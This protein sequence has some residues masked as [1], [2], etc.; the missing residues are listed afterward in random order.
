MRNRILAG[1]VVLCVTVFGLLA[2]IS[3]AAVIKLKNGNTIE[4]EIGVITDSEVTVEIP[5]LGLMTFTISEVALIN[6]EPVQIQ[7][8]AGEKKGGNAAIHYSKASDLLLYPTFKEQK[9]AIDSVIEGSWGQDSQGLETLL[10]QNEAFFETFQNGLGVERCDFSFGSDPSLKTLPHML[11]TRDLTNLVLLKIRYD[12]HLGDMDS[13]IGGYLSLL[14]FA[15]HF[16]Q[17]R[18]FV[19]VMLVEALEQQTVRRLKEYVSSP[20]ATGEQNQRIAK[21]LSWYEDARPTVNQLQEIERAAE[22][23]Q[24]ALTPGGFFDNIPYKRVELNYKAS[25]R[26][27]KELRL[28]AVEKSG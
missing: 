15:Q 17:T 27:L 4:G 2:E 28:L 25:L 19:A 13:A 6:G 7:A 22:A 8:Q 11:R 20:E 3:S 18:R 10:K 9:D 26:A 23:E 12:E 24:Q 1:N 5:D 14:T 21:F 16:G